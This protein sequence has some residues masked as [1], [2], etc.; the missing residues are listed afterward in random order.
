MCARLWVPVCL[1]TVGVVAAP[2]EGMIEGSNKIDVYM[3]QGTRI[4]AVALASM[5]RETGA[6]M[7]SIGFDVRWMDEPNEVTAAFLVVVDLEGSCN[8]WP[9]TA[10]QSAVQ[11]L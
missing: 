9:N 8:P 4:S 10:T 2:S 3:H 1:L 5:Q 11:R 6:L 7:E